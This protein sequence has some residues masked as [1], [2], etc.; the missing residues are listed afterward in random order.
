M[1]LQRW[2][3]G[4]DAIV[5]GILLACGE[6]KR[7]II[8]LCAIAILIQEGCGSLDFGS[9][10]LWYLATVFLFVIGKSL[11]VTDSLIFIVLF[12]M[13]IGGIQAVVIYTFSTLQNTAVPY[14]ALMWQ[15]MAQALLIPP[16]YTLA[17]LARKRYL[18]HVDQN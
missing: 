9:A 3:P 15:G 17:S 7:Q 6:G 4:V 1:A 11:F 8:A 5:P 14:D 18:K 16:L 2:L 12:S 13:C 10:I